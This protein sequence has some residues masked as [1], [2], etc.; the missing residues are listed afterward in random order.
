MTRIDPALAH[1]LAR[2]LKKDEN[3]AF[4]EG[5]RR[6]LVQGSACPN[7]D[8]IFYGVC[9]QHRFCRDCGRRERFRWL[10]N[11]PRVSGVWELEEA[12]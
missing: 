9:F 10:P 5:L 8:Y 6:R 2:Q 1:W 7:H 12:A 4:A 3:R 11:D